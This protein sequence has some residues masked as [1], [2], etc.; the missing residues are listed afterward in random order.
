MHATLSDV[1][2]DT[3]QNSLEAGALKVELS[4]VENDG[5]ISVDIIDNG[6]GMD[7][8]I[9]AR[10]FDPFYT[11]PGKHDKRKVGLGLP[12]LKQICESCGGGVSL[13]SEKGIGTHLSYFFDANNID[14][15]P[16]GNLPETIVTLFNYPGGGE[17]V[18]TH[19]KNGDEYSISRAELSDAV[20][21]L[22][23]LDGIN[24]ALEFIRSQ[25]DSL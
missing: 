8:N 18:F 11:E 15:P 7:E 19:K 12:L 21:G 23:S 2:A 16:M 3:V 14:L 25:E 22:E 1:I 6:K 4:I 13:K 10:V 17:I 20:G 24:L 9:L 5:K